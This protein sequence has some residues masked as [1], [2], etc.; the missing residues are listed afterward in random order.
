[1]NKKVCFKRILDAAMTVLSVLLMGGIFLFP[2]DAVHEILGTVLIALWILHN[3]LNR[4]FYKSLFKGKYSAARVV[5]LCVNAGTLVCAALLAV[6]GVMLSNCV[7]AFLG[8]ERGMGFARRPYKNI[9]V[10]G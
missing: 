8:I 6:S 7:F 9:C 5:M 2:S 4:A 1:M 3:V 10:N